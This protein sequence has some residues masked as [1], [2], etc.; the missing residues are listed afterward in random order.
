MRIMFLVLLISL[1]MSGSYCRSQANIEATKYTFA[2]NNDDSRQFG[3]KKWEMDEDQS[4]ISVCL[5]DDYVYLADR[6]HSN[7]KRIDLRTGRLISS[8]PISSEMYA[9]LS[10]I[11]V[12]DNSVFVSCVVDS[13]YVLELNLEFRK[14]FPIGGR[15]QKFFWE[16][17]EKTLDVSIQFEG[18]VVS[19]S[20]DSTIGLYRSAQPLW[21][22]SSAHG[23]EYSTAKEEGRHYFECEYFA[24]E[25]EGPLPLLWEDKF[26]AINV[27]FD[28]SRLVY[29]D[30]DEKQFTLYVYDIPEE[31]RKLK[32][33][34]ADTLHHKE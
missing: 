13:I 20:K 31:N 29:Y 14:S 2:I 25:L 32:T 24:L 4:V 33:E 26:N 6:Y 17:T 22:W 21:G 9:W 5:F 7:I 8:S 12:I 28:S 30:V 34:A 15:L 3:Y 23:K 16:V 10:D 27:E 19:I 1:A 11:A 18:K